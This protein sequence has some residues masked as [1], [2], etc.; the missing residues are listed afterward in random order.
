[1]SFISEWLKEFDQEMVSTR[2]CIE[3]VPTDKGQWKPHPKSFPIGH[4][5]QLLAGMP[6]WS[7]DVAKG[8]NIDLTKGSGYSF[9]P[10]EKL[11]A[12]F[13]K[14]VAAA[15]AAVGAMSEADLDKDWSLVMG[16]KTLLTMPR[17]EVLRQNMGHLSHHRGQMS[18]YLRLLDI[19]VPAIYGPSADDRGGF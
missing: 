10:T 6:G 12:T 5:A 2:H 8:N 9:E 4:L 16:E 19:P 11:L 15:K 14:N 7:V 3:R 18:V 1:M 17:R 13:D